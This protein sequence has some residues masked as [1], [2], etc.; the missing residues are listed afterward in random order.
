MSRHSTMTLPAPRSPTP[1]WPYSLWR[2][3]W[4]IP[5]DWTGWLIVQQLA[6][7]SS[8][9]LTEEAYAVPWWCHSHPYCST[10]MSWHPDDFDEKQ[11]EIPY[12]LRL[13]APFPCQ[14]HV[15]RNSRSPFCPLLSTERVA[16]DLKNNTSRRAGHDARGCSRKTVQRKGLA[17]P[18]TSRRPLPTIES[19]QNVKP[20]HQRNPVGRI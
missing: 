13:H 2:C 1:C 5:T 17:L 14:H 10:S 11:S 9:S 3:M 16:A 15:P 7:I 6:A 8:Q 20:V 18:T 12:F 19:R 4:D